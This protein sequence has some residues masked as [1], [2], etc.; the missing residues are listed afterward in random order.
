MSAAVVQRAAP[1]T[2]GGAGTATVAYTSTPTVGNKLLFLIGYH[3]SD[4]VTLAAGTTLF[5]T[6]NNSINGSSASVQV[7][8]RDVQAGDGK[9]WAFVSGTGDTVTVD[10]YEI[11][12]AAAGSTGFETIGVNSNT[13]NPATNGQVTKT[14]SSSA[15]GSLVFSFMSSDPNYTTVT[16]STGGW[17]NLAFPSGGHPIYSS[18]QA[19]AASTVYTSTWA[20]SGATTTAFWTGGILVIDAGSSTTPITGNDSTTLTEGTTVITELIATTD[21]GA[22]TEA[23]STITLN[24]ASTE[25]TLT[26]GSTVI[27]AFV[28]GTPD[29]ATEAEGATALAITSASVDSS[30]LSDPTP[31]VNMGTVSIVGVDSSTLTEGTTVVTVQV[32]G[33]PD[34]AT[35][36]ELA[37]VV[38]ALLATGDVST[39]TELATAIGSAFGTVDTSTLT[40]SSSIGGNTLK[41]AGDGWVLSAVSA[42]TKT[43]VSSFRSISVTVSFTDQPDVVVSWE[44]G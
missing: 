18:D 17:T 12:G 5:Q 14:S 32:A 43:D 33:S 10:A 6:L 4:T 44:V 39:L 20:V 19:G 41:T 35:E 3:G 16:Q 11:S 38:T 7:V 37:T 36:T 13:T 15:A 8:Y 26:E 27:A 25:G 30:T 24:D 28:T 34:S 40:D 22:L 2:N 21:A 23:Q 1:V 31:V 29:T 42:V 9:N